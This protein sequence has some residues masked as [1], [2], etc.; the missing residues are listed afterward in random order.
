LAVIKTKAQVTYFSVGM[1]VFLTLFKIAVSFITGSTAILSEALH[2]GSDLITSL[3]AMFS[4]RESEKPPDIEHPYGHGKFE[5]I[6]SLFEAFIIFA[7][8]VIIIY[9]SV[10][11]LTIGVELVYL[12]L[13]ITTMLISA[14]IN[15]FVSSYLIKKGRE[16][17]SPVIE[18]DGWHSRTDV[19]TAGGVMLSLIIVR[20]TGIKI[21]DPVIALGVALVILWV[22]IRIFLE[23]FGILVDRSLPPEEEKVVRDIIEKHKDRYLEFHQMRSRKKGSER[24]VDLHLVFPDGTTLKEAHDL[25]NH[26][27]DEV[28]R[29]FPGIKILIHMEP[30]EDGKNVE[31]EN[32]KCD[33][34][35][36]CKKDGNV[37]EEAQ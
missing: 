33:I 35:K 27:E 1:N 16:M 21:L 15:Y 8:G 14:V 32:R 31:V 17:E 12:E 11:Q 34:C 36:E 29:E 9:R 7:T 37:D 24:E 23:S 18:A 26:L 30:C 19:F 10:K 20:I 28:R 25:T 22:A 4:V 5:N 3:I 6:A 13:G 2:S